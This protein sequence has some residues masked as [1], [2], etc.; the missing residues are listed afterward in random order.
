MVVKSAIAMNSGGIIAGRMAM[1]C[2]AREKWLRRRVNASAAAVVITEE[3]TA[4]STAACRLTQNA[5]R[6]CSSWKISRNQR[7]DKP[8]IGQLRLSEPLNAYR[9]TTASGR[10]R[11][12]ISP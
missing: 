12:T 4:V 10:Y 5:V 7:N 3:I 9:I 11:N 8:C 2:T 1:P 6:N